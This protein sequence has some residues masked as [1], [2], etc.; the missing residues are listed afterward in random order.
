MT[1]HFHLVEWEVLGAFYQ[2][3]VEELPT[4]S[5]GWDINVDGEAIAEENRGYYHTY[6][7]EGRRVLFDDHASEG[8]RSVTI[9]GSVA[10]SHIDVA[11]A[12]YEF[13]SGTDAELQAALS[14]LALAALA[15]RRRRR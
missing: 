15:T 4:A 3:N 14:V 2:A 7:T 9:E 11:A 13:K 5:T 8:Q 12:G 10:A 6:A 1:S